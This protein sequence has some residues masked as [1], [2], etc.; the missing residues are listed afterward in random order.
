MQ[1]GVLEMSGSKRGARDIS[2]GSPRAFNYRV[3]ASDMDGTFL[4][5]DHSVPA[6]NIQ[7]VLECIRRGILFLPATGKSRA[8]AMA[9]VGPLASLLTSNDS[10]GAPGVYIQGL[11]VYGLR[12]ELVYQQTLPRETAR[13]LVRVQ[14]E[15]RFGALVAY[16]GDRIVC[17]ER[18]TYTERLVP[19]HEPE[20]DDSHG[21]AWERLLE[22]PE[23]EFPIHK[24]LFVDSVERIRELRPLVEEAFSTTTL[25]RT[26]PPL[27]APSNQIGEHTS[28]PVSRQHLVQHTSHGRCVQACPDMLEVLPANANKGDGLRRLLEH[29]GI[30]AEEVVA[31]GDAEND[32]EM[33]RY[34]GLG[35]AVGNALPILKD[36]ADVVLDVTNDD[37]AVAAAVERFFLIHSTT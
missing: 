9:S 14:R 2:T 34:A 13:E 21:E 8:G 24:M 33:I 32:I 31:I 3:I 23:H 25:D 7:A 30:R 37:A 16:S 29:L 11:V 17:E 20:P 22:R 19:Y 6:R 15:L 1:P 26:R 18:N 12:G 36:A 35:I 4:A 5:R 28:S 10:H 27:N